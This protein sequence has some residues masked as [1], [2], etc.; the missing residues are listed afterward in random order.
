MRL[1][2]SVLEAVNSSPEGTTTEIIANIIYGDLNQYTTEQARNYRGSKINTKAREL[3]RQG[4]IM[5]I[6][7]GKT[8]H[9][10]PFNTDIKEA[11]I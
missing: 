4:Y 7:E 2:D 5:A 6:Y 10:Y 8:P 3:W 11:M 1:I 9:W